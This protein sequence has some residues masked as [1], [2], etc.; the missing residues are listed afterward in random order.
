ML[1]GDSGPSFVTNENL[2][3]LFSCSLDSIRANF[4]ACNRIVAISGKTDSRP[5]GDRPE[6]YRPV[7]SEPTFAYEFWLQGIQ[8]T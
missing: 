2:M 1:I 7:R 3:P 8:L 4:V 5:A 6:T